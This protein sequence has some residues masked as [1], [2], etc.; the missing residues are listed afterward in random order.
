MTTQDRRLAFDDMVASLPRLVAPDREL[1]PG[2]DY[3]INEAR[4]SYWQRQ[5]AL[6]A[7]ILVVLGLSLY[8]GHAQPERTQ[9][10]Q[11]RDYLLGLQSEQQYARQALLVQYRD[12]ITVNADWKSQLRELEQAE[13]AIYQALQEEPD[14]L[15]LFKILRRVQ[16]KQLNLIDSAFEPR[17]TSI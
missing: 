17:L 9:D 13:Q 6:A 1:W 12:S 5:L 3:A 7:S 16:Q 4:G 10:M 2:I 11:M 15:E 14:N 8:F